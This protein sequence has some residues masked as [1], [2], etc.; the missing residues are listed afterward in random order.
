M[1]AKV[2][3]PAALQGKELP[4]DCLVF[5]DVI[6]QIGNYLELK[7]QLTPETK[8]YDAAGGYVFPGFID[9]HAHLASWGTG[10]RQVNLEDTHSV[11]QALEMLKSAVK[12][13]TPG[14]WV[15][16]VRWDESHWQEQRYWTREELD[17]AIPDHPVCAIRICGHMGVLNTYALRLL[18]MPAEQF[19]K[20]W[21][22]EALLDEVRQKLL[23]AKQQR[24][25]D[26]LSAANFAVQMGI[27]G[28][29]EIAHLTDFE[30]YHELAEEGKLPL[31]VY[32]LPLYEEWE[33]K[34]EKL[35]EIPE[36]LW[37]RG[38]KF[39]AD[40]SLGAR[41]AKLKEAYADA[42]GRGEWVLSPEEL[43]AGVEKVVQAGFQPAIHAIGD[44]AIEQTL[45]TLEHIHAKTALNSLRPRIEHFEMCSTEHIER[46]KRL[47][48]IA[49]MQPNFT[50]KWGGIGGLYQKRLGLPRAGRMNPLLEIALLE[51][52]MA[53]G[54]DM[55]PF[56]PLFGIRSAVFPPHQRQKIREHQA[57]WAYTFGGAFAAFAESFLGTIERGKK[58]D[59]I[60]LDKVPSEFPRL[61]FVFINGELKYPE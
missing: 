59:L 55:M 37:V 38:V 7:S 60:V 39:F 48:G 15:I 25:K 1:D 43:Q 20:G 18:N 11:N 16:G 45:K 49:S 53:F 2:Y 52:P 57:V 50:G 23:P 12:N 44:E 27:T 19:P 24:K 13:R 41:T 10:Q 51:C 42:S 22:K 6:E 29:H 31:R 17:N 9:A 4:A 54:S 34:K 33:G 32:F 46:L 21:V 58:A 35:P 61:Q 56:S 28:I 5:S 40:G 8:I 36:W 30:I 47:G 14:D 26:I 3:T